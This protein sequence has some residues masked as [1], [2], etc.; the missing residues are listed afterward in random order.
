MHQRLEA[1]SSLFIFGE[2]GRLYY[3]DKHLMNRNGEQKM[4]GVMADTLQ[5]RGL[6]E[7][8]YNVTKT[9]LKPRFVLDLMEKQTELL[10]IHEI[11]GAV[12]IELEE[13]VKSGE[14]LIFQINSQ[15]QT[16]ELFEHP[17]RELLDLDKHLRSIIGSLKVEAAKKF[18]L[19]ESIAKERRKLEEFREYDRVYDG[20]IK[21]DITKQIDDL[22]EDLKVRRESIDLL[23]GRLKNQIMSFHETIAKVLD[24]DTSVGKKIRTLFREQGITIA[25]ILMAIGMDIGVLVEALLPDGG[26]VTASGGE[27][28][29]KDERGL[30][31]WI[32]NK[33]KALASLLGRLRIKDAEALPG[34]I[35]GIISWI[36]NRV[37]DVVGWVS[38]NVWAL[39]VGF[40]GL[41]YTYIGRTVPQP[42]QGPLVTRK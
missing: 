42:L 31:E 13:I 20:A 25:S 30:K 29:P 3:K 22:N 4:I 16:D 7:I 12:E 32:R 5:I 15:S 23:K 38:Q 28:P 1:N 18:E 19:E 10:S 39:A 14:D 33:F 40:G 37:K 11:A 6:R 35:V 8:G 36:L 2:E 17:L 21:E 9:N 24:K 34:I 41:I 26:G 27:P